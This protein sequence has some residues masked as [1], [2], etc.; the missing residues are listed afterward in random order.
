MKCDDSSA[1]RKVCSLLCG[2]QTVPT[3]GWL[4]CPLLPSSDNLNG[5]ILWERYNANQAGKYYSNWA[6]KQDH[7]HY[8]IDSD[9]VCDVAFAHHTGPNHD[10]FF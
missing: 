6:K 1:I 7:T 9:P 5:L 3:L 4:T 8:G 10:D 2:G